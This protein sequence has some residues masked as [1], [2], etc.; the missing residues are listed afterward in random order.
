M[1]ECAIRGG[2]SSPAGLLD[3]S[4]DDGGE[5]MR[6]RWDSSRLEGR[7][8]FLVPEERTEGFLK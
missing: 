2:I 7:A 5:R 3:G 1:E 6:G 4:R 8:G